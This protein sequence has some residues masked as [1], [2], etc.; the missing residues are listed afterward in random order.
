[1][2]DQPTVDP[3]V[4]L[5]GVSAVELSGVELWWVRPG[6]TPPVKRWAA[7]PRSG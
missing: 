1:L 2:A 5:S 3:A 6:I 4:V 7:A